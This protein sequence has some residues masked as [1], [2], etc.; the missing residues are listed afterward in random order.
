[1]LHWADDKQAAHACRVAMTDPNRNPRRAQE[2]HTRVKRCWLFPKTLA[3]FGRLQ[4]AAQQT[5]EETVG[6]ATSD[7][8][9]PGEQTLAAT[10]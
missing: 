6:A 3:T 5:T 8:R 1:M 9:K 10:T 2:G 4:L 7:S